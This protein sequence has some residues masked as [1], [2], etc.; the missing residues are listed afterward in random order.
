MNS[1]EFEIFANAWADAHE[2]MSAG[3]VL[4]ERAM[5]SVFDDLA[6]YPLESVLSAISYHRKTARFAPVP[7]DVIAILDAGNKRPSPDEAWAMMP[8]DESETVVWTT[9]MA[10]A[11]SIVSGLIA[12]GDNIAARMAFRSAYER[13]CNEAALIRR[14]V[15]WKVCLGFDKEKIK[16]VLRQAVMSGRI[17]REKA[18]AFLPHPT[19]SG[20]IGK[21]LTGKKLSPSDEREDLKR[22][23][24]VV[25]DA[26]QAGQEK[27]DKQN[28]LKALDLAQKQQDLERR[29]A[30]LVEQ[31]FSSHD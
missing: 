24:D 29:R 2:V 6:E 13:L 5:V 21:L 23:V 10:E 11:Y 14:P 18:I 16:P 22:L 25:R 27:H 30:E 9:E 7:A 3:K 20:P 19:D 4:S 31:A 15:E 8:N 17:S 28:A 12:D 26:L 1:Q